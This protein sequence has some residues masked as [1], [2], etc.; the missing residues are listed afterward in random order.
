MRVYE[1]ALR[2]TLRRRWLVLG[3]AAAMLL[4]TV[5]VFMRLGS[6]FMPPLDEGTLFYMPSTMPGISIGEAQRLLQATRRLASLLAGSHPNS[7]S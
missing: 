2:W 4:A 5:P 6:E 1:P 7:I 3:A